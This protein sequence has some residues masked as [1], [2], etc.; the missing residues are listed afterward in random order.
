MYKILS[1]LVIT[2]KNI[3]RVY[4]T[5]IIKFL[6]KK[7]GQGLKVN[8]YSYFTKGIVEV[9][10]NCN[11]NGMI[12][13]A[14]KESKIKIGNYFH[15]GQECLIIAQNHNYEGTKIP[16]DSTYISKDVIIE[17]CV[18]FGSRVTVL[19]GVTIGEGAIIQAGS[20]VSSN[21]PAYSIAGG[22]PARVFKYRDWEHYEELKREK[23]FH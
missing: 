5:S 14:G 6:C 10:N 19:G 23:K 8:G 22:N 7:Y 16:Y 3:R 17:D 18:W 20:V 13:Q 9:G 12:I 2:W 11:F 4:F 15:S 21:I 1:Y